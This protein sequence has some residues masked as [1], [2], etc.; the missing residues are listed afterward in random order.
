MGKSLGMYR[1]GVPIELC[2]N[3]KVN[4]IIM[5]VNRTK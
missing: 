1:K 5:L 3:I 4:L 2:N